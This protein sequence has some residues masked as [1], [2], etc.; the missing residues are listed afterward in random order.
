MVYSAKISWILLLFIQLLAA[1]KVERVWDVDRLGTSPA[2]SANAGGLLCQV[3][4]VTAVLL[5][6]SNES[7]N[8]IGNTTFQGSFYLKDPLSDITLDQPIKFAA[9][10]Q[11]D[12]REQRTTDPVSSQWGQW[13]CDIEK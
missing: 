3:P 2:C 5:R 1:Q 4:N 12:A 11:E 13:H 9:G 6:Q 10:M 7:N 8:G